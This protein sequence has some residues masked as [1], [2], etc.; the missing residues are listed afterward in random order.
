MN[1]ANEFNV[2]VVV[3]TYCEA[4]NL[5]VLIPRL[6]GILA[7]AGINSEILIVDDESP[8]NTQEVCESLAA[9]YPVRLIVRKGERGLSSAVIRGMRQSSGKVLVVMDADLSHPPE[10][11]PELY[12]AVMADEAD[13]A[14]GSRYVP[15][16]GTD[17]HW[18]LF[19]WLNSKV[20][21]LLAWPLTSCRDPMSGFF[22]LRKDTF[23]AAEKLSPV[24]YKIGLELIVKC[25]CQRIKEVPILF[26]NR[27][28]GESKLSLREQFLYL[29]HL[30]RLYQYKL[31][32]VFGRAMRGL[33]RRT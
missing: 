11:V 17:D 7:E 23:Q 27:L 5:A 8:D 13:F 18:G 3:P 9:M 12:I 31:G 32:I 20:A 19:R 22:A 25:D 14:V 16:G 1:A 26:A 29:R 24:G 2:S 30:K 28:H 33:K 15:G 4:E 21:T 10:K 6:S